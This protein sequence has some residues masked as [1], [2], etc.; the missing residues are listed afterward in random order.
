MSHP[1]PAHVTEHTY[2]I[3]LTCT[4]YLPTFFSLT[5]LPSGT[6]SK[7]PARYTAEWRLYSNPPTFPGDWLASK[8]A[9]HEDC[10]LVNKF[11]SSKSQRRCG[12]FQP[13]IALHVSVGRSRIHEAGS[14]PGLTVSRFLQDPISLGPGV[15]VSHK[16]IC[17]LLHLLHSESDSVFRLTPACL[18]ISLVVYSLFSC[19]HC[20][21]IH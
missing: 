5:V 17:T 10:D 1:L 19:S 4:T 15:K 16:Q 13:D 8:I 9:V 14:F 12:V 6:G 18:A 20:T 3:S 7:N 21:L 11:L 2:T